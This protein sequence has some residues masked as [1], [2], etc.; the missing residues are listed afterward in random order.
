VGAPCSQW[1]E[2][3]YVAIRTSW[4]EATTWWH[5]ARQGAGALDALAQRFAQRCRR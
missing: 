2:D 4:A 5:A 3:Q 1:F